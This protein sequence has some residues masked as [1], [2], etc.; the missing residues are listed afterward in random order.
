MERAIAEGESGAP[1]FLSPDTTIAGFSAANRSSAAIQF[2]RLSGVVSP[3]YMRQ[4]FVHNV[5]SDD[6]AD[7]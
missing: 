7:R 5:A 1:G 6:Q 3:T 2:F 4:W